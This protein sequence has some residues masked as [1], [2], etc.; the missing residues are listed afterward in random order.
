M[1]K[2]V[3]FLEVIGV[4]RIGSFSYDGSSSWKRQDFKEF[5]DLILIAVFTIPIRFI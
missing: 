3:Q 1:A 5:A 4:V 2:G